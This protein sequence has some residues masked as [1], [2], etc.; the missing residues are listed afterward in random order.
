M[1]LL[2]KIS[3]KYE[4]TRSISVADVKGYLQKEYDRAFERENEIDR[5]EKEN[6]EL[7]KISLKYDAMC[8]IQDNTQKRIEKQD[9]RIKE[10]QEEIKGL[11]TQIKLLNSKNYDIKKNAEKTIEEKNNTIKALKKEIKNLEKNQVA[12]ETENKKVKKTK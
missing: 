9:A 4:L 5:L 7:K 2:T 11:E 8:V 10:Y 3:D 12:N 1:G 6:K